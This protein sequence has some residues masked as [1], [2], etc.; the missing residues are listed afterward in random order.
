[1]HIVQVKDLPAL[2]DFH[3]VEAVCYAHDY[4][5]LPVDPIESLTPLLRGEHPTGETQ[6]LYVGYENGRPA[7]SLTVTMFTLDNL[8]SANVEG[9]VHPAYR[10]R[11]LGRQLM[12]HAIDVVRSAGRTRIF[13]EAHWLPSGEEGPSFPLL[14]EVGAKPVLDDLRRVLDVQEHPVGEPA[15]VPEGYRIVQWADH[16][17]DELVDGLAYLLYSMVLDAPMGDMD[18]EPETWDAARYRDSER[19][20]ISRARRRF[21]TAVVHEESGAVAGETELC[22]NLGQPLVSHQW[23]TIVD[24]DHRGRGLGLV[25]KTWNHSQVVKACPD[26]RWILTWNATSNSYMIDV[27]EKLGFRV[28]EKWTEWQLDL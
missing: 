22:V 14:R 6:D 17:P 28:A 21:V 9:R 3:G 23:N 12:E 25:L 19:E 16:A 20:S 26:V 15:A 8:T 1:V 13:F 4:D 7:A 10:R 11:G 18:Y 5:C 24:P 27:N 2:Q